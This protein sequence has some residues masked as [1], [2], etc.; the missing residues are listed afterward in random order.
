M[1]LGRGRG[2]FRLDHRNVFFKG[3]IVFFELLEHHVAQHVCFALQLRTLFHFFIEL[4]LLRRNGIALRRLGS[5]RRPTRCHGCT[6][7]HSVIDSMN[8]LVI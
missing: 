3:G 1:R 5:A 7:D 8:F 4:R 6:I 2:D